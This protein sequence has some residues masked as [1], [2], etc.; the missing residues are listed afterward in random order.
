MSTRLRVGLGILFV[1]CLGGLLLLPRAHPRPEGEPI[2]FEDYPEIQ[3]RGYLCYRAAKP[4]TI[5]GKLDDAAWQS[6]PWSEAF[7]DIEG[8]RKPAPRFRT[9]MKMLW[10]DQYF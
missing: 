10:D 6:A 7:I 5:D 3:P 2:T 1:A 4:I 8:D 9:R